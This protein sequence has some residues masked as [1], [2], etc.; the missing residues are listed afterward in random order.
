M[1]L[2]D[3]NAGAAPP[4]PIGP[5]VTVEE[6]VNHARINGITV[7]AQ[8]ELLSQ[9]LRAAVN[10]CQQFLRRSLLTQT[11]VGIFVPDG[12]SCSCGGALL[13]P[14]GK[15][16]AVNKVTTPAGVLD[17][18]GFTWNGY[19]LVTLSAPANGTTAVEFDSGYGDDDALIEDLII[20]GIYRYATTLYENRTGEGDARYQAEA[21][22][23]L[24]SGVIDCW[25]PYQIEVS[26]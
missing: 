24:P 23:T 21:G 25:R 20:E 19:N 3:I 1:R 17:S 12:S 8:P 13:L 14:R 9:D 4:D 26:G 16:Q 18:S 11:L 6:F 7:Q 5:L 10:R 2:I 22:R 15:V